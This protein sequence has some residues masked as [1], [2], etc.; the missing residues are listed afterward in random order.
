MEPQRLFR[1]AGRRVLRASRHPPGRRRRLCG[2]VLVLT[3]GRPAALRGYWELLRRPGVVH[4]RVQPRGELIRVPSG[5]RDRH[6][7]AGAVDPHLIG[8]IGVGVRALRTLSVQHVPGRRQQPRSRRAGYG[9]ARVQV[10]AGG[11]QIRHRVHRGGRGDL[12]AVPASPGHPNPRGPSADVSSGGGQ[13]VPGSRPLLG[14]RDCCA[15][16]LHRR[17]GPAAAA[18]H[19]HANRLRELRPAPLRRPRL[20]QLRRPAA[21]PGVDRT[22][23]PARPVHRR[24]A[25]GYRGP[26][27][28][29]G[30]EIYVS[31]PHDAVRTRL[32][33]PMPR[34]FVLPGWGV[35]VRAAAHQLGRR[36]RARRSD[37][38]QVP[39][40]GAACRNPR[41]ERADGAREQGGCPLGVCA[42]VKLRGQVA[43]RSGL[44]LDVLPPNPG[45]QGRD[46]LHGPG[47]RPSKEHADTWGSLQCVVHGR[48]GG[49]GSGGVRDDARG[50]HEGSQQDQGG[51]PPRQP[52]QVAR[53][54]R[55]GVQPRRDFIFPARPQ[56]GREA[57]WDSRLLLGVRAVRESRG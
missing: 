53:E 6:L 49:R 37:I 13:R 9:V 20:A 24:D 55:A 36:R 52:P 41:G 38:A 12:G 35:L 5:P 42:A 57:R 8:A 40:R 22:R 14:P 56:G 47:A 21:D 54:R 2:H 48:A 46:P 16:V 30:A 34:R 18:N 23:L 4:C 32:S 51:Q 28:D 10:G 39:E 44:L 27:R 19:R 17:F 15:R 33:R 43:R 1:A 29:V 11:R 31:D 7:R 26:R 50:S 3:R 45:V 25:R